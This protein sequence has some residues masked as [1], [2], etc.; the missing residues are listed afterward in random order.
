V[1]LPRWLGRFERLFAANGDGRGFIV[2]AAPSLADVALVLLSENL[3]DNG[4]GGAYA[5]APLLAAHAE[6]MIARP[7]IHRY[8]TSPA[9]FPPQLL[10]T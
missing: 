3:R 10:P 4:F 9:R 8:V 7:G 6:R 5:G 2:G 1:V